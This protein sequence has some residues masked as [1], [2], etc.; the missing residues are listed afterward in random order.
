MNRNEINSDDEIYRISAQSLPS[1]RSHSHKSEKRFHSTTSPVQ[2]SEE[3][4]SFY[5]NREFAQKH[6]RP[7]TSSRSHQRNAG[8]RNTRFTLRH[9][10]DH[11][12]QSSTSEIKCYRCGNSNHYSHQCEIAK[13]KICHSCGKKGHLSKICQSKHQQ[14]A[15]VTYLQGEDSGS[16]DDEYTFALS[17]TPQDAITFT[18]LINS[19]PCSVLIDS[20]SSVNIMDSTTFQLFNATLKPY[21]KKVFVYNSNVPLDILG[22]FHA[23]ISVN[24]RTTTTNFLVT[25]GSAPTIL[26]RQTSIQLDMLRIGPAP[27]TINQVTST[28]TS[29]PPST[30]QQ[31]D[32]LLN[33]YHDRFEGLG[34]LKD[35]NVKIHVDPDVIPVAQ[36][37]RRLPILMQQELDKEIDKLLDLH[38]L[39][40][41]TQPP[42]WINPLVIVPKRTKGF[43]VC[44]DM[45]I[46]NS[47]I[48]REPYQVP[49]L[50]EILH[51]FNG[52]NYFTTLDLNQGYHQISLDQPSRDLT[53]FACHRGILRYT[54]LIYGMSPASEIYQREIEKILTGLPG[55]KN[56]SDDIIIGAHTPEE[57]LTRMKDTFDRLRHHNITVNKEKCKFMREKITYMGHTLSK[58]GV[59]PDQLKIQSIL[60]LEPPRNVKEL[61]SFLGMVT[62]CAKFIPQYAT[63]SYPLRSLLQKGKQFKW[64]TKHQQ[65][66]TQLKEILLST[67]S[68]AFFNPSAPT[69]IVVDASPV[70]LGA[71]LTQQQPCGTFKPVSYASRALSKVEQRYSQIERESLAILFGIERFKL[72]LYGIKFLVIT[73]HKPLIH[74]FKTTSKPPPR[75][76]RWI[77]KLQPYQFK[78]QY[79]PGHSNPA[80]YLSRSNPLE[81]K[82][83]HNPAE[84]FIHLVTQLQTP[85]AI[86]IHT[87]IQ[88]T[89]NDP[90][91]KLL[92]RAIESGT[93]LQYEQLKMFYPVQHALT[94]FA[95]LILLNDKIVIPKK[96]QEQI[97]AL[98]HEG[99]QG[100]VR[101]KQRLRSKVWWPGIN[102]M[103][104]S[105]I[106]KCH[107]C[108]VVS[109]STPK[110]PITPTPLP[111]SSWIMLGC[112][113]CGPFP[114][115]EH[116]LVCVDY[117]S[118][119]PDVEIVHKINANTIVSKLRKLFCRYGAPEVLVTDNGPQFIST[120]MK[121]LLQEF[122]ICHRK[123][124][125]YHPAA[126]GEVERFNRTLKKFIQ[127]AIAEHKD[128]RKELDR[129]LMNY[130]NTP[131]PGTGFSP[132]QLMFHRPVRDKL[133]ALPSTPTQRKPFNK[134]RQVDRKYKDKMESNSNRKSRTQTD[135][136]KPGDL[137]LIKN[138]DKHRD[139]YTSVWNPTP[140]PVLQTKGNSILIKK[141]HQA[142]L[143]YQ[144]QVKRYHYPEINHHH[145][146]L[147]ND[148]SDEES[149]ILSD[150]ITS[151]ETLDQVLSDDES[152]DDTI[153]Y[154]LSDNESTNEPPVI[155][156][157]RPTRNRMPPKYLDNYQT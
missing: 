93:L 115:G 105:F 38:V 127:A 150:P 126:N 157:N 42:S 33:D 134:V 130:R 119:Y 57:L 43:R 55:V 74:L 20:G 21:T 138:L 6:N 4:Q 142:I 87:I 19:K 106:Q 13:D 3:E 102:K 85:S 75:I 82:P 63:I 125:P 143:R 148:D 28:D 146:Q 64:K 56:I 133:P 153:P 14:P 68:L 139:K 71:V 96:L 16:S 41:V 77:L 144:D 100:I 25:K 121:T 11:H 129:F 104:E 147:C 97:I 29:I 12:R 116:L 23:T 61:R 81:L 152:S 37:P 156:Q 92:K 30:Q 66:F 154:Q 114:T 49:T 32:C 60:S 112:D 69:E 76:E 31:L 94:T 145:P 149:S 46:A 91:L 123:V 155:P 2:S 103:V 110:I 72:Y 111:R 132:S 18:A 51:T 8:R 118:R 40:P 36:K 135:T 35:V 89:L 67:D 88:H 83:P 137:V 44:V 62:Y 52:C 22:A 99:H 78:V 54:R 47:A 7:S 39:E 101:T 80:D 15:F 58:D 90:T 48:I 140:L 10:T 151:N 70:G 1:D 131:H 73:D 84:E 59:S 136:V 79:R 141:N 5:I 17:L 24:N 117:Y 86:S 95:D 124:T 27:N 120:E 34:N 45:R 98:A 9:Q 109:P 107:P 128:W 53:A 26:S 122:N 113:L 65:A 108:Q 50:D